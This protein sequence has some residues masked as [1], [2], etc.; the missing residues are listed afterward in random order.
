[1]TDFQAPPPSGWPGPPAYS[2]AD[3]VVF[4]NQRRYESD[5]I[6]NFWTAFGW[7][8]LTCGIYGYYVVFQ[9]VRRMRD[10]NARRLELLDAALAFSWEEAGKRGVQEELTPSY[11][12]A[13]AHL[14]VMR[15]MTTDFRE[16]WIWLLICLV[17]G[18]IGHIV[19]FVLLDQDLVKH[20]QAEVGIEQELATIFGRLG[21][22]LPMP[23]GGRVKG[24]H[25]YVARIIV[26][27]VTLGIYAIWWQYNMMIEPNGHFQTNWQEEDE[28]V[29]A[30]TALRQP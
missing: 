6:F 18:G 9:L 20:D 11:Q 23:N 28:L 15:Q 29:T 12:R 16:P 14:A 17:A 5:Y 2:P 21:H 10:H 1:V 24:Q 8:L 22:T 26:S 13:G 19:L 30:V 27:I 7:T 4:A 3:R 25:N